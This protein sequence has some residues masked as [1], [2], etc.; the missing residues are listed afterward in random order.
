VY[1]LDGSGNEVAEALLDPTVAGLESANDKGVSVGTADGLAYVLVENDTSYWAAAIDVEAGNHLWTYILEDSLLPPDDKHTEYSFIHSMHI[2][3]SADGLVV[4]GAT[5]RNTHPLLWGLGF[6]SLYTVDQDSGAFI[7]DIQ[8]PVQATGEFTDLRNLTVDSRRG[9][10]AYIGEWQTASDR[11]KIVATPIDA[12]GFGTPYRY[13][14]PDDGLYLWGFGLGG[15]P[16]DEVVVGMV[17]Q[18]HDFVLFRY[19]G[20]DP[21]VVSVTEVG[22][23]AISEPLVVLDDGDVITLRND[24]VRRISPSGSS[25]SLSVPLSEGYIH[26]D[27]RFETEPSTVFLVDDGS[28]LVHVSW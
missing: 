6:V 22:G 13:T 27:S 28:R 16:D 23:A 14:T 11:S 25:V 3:A 21:S 8:L 19:H 12:A 15:L 26:H 9:A 1:Q 4:I 7:D 18:V 24:V 2:D 17:P 5:V 10:I 20:T